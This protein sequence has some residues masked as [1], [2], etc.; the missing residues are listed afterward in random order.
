LV[1]DANGKPV[2]CTNKTNVGNERLAKDI[3]GIL[4]RKRFKPA[5]LRDGQKVYAILDTFLTMFLP[6]TDEGRK[7]MSLRMAPDAELQ[8]TK[9]P[10]G[11]S[12]EISIIL[13]YDASGKITDC[14]P[15]N[16]EKDLKMADVACSQ[17]ILFD[18]TIQ[19]DPSGQPVAYVTQKRIRFTTTS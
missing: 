10:D 8:V 5:T 17:R 2:Q 13:A 4:S 15:A 12:P 7:I 9:L 14:G 3:C 18:H 19:K 16:R 1:V 6:D 11:S